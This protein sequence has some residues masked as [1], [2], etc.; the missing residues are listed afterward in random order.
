[1]TTKEL[2]EPLLIMDPEDLIRI[3]AES[4]ADLLPLLRE[5][6][7]EYD[8]AGLIITIFAST[9]NVD[10]VISEE[11]YLYLKGFFSAVGQPMSK[12]EI[13]TLIKNYSGKN[14]EELV[15]SFASICDAKEGSALAL[16]VSCICAIDKK[17]SRE[18]YELIISLL[19]A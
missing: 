8:G 12:D 10:G 4:Y 13:I 5:I 11:E 18:E 2:L 15:K 14:A 19:N 9:I 1:M 16:L 7:P 17:F 3:S 6:D